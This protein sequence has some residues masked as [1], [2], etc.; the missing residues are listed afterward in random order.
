M[1][2]IPTGIIRPAELVL[3]LNSFT[4]SD[5]HYEQTRGVAVGPR[6][7]LSF[8]CCCAGYV[9]GRSR[10][11]PAIPKPPETVSHSHNSSR[12]RHTC[13][14]DQDFRTQAKT[15]VDFLSNRVCR[16]GFAMKLDS[17]V[18]V[19]EAATLAADGSGNDCC[20]DVGITGPLVRGR[21]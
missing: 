1:V 2:H 11:G 4:F 3:T 7:G 14:D 8:A 21:G 12:L 18:V 16:M 15:E 9:M 13:S 17:V 6:M 10:H 19:R 5:Q 20:G